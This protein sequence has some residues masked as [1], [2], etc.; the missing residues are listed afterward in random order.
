ML[1]LLLMLL[2]RSD[3]NKRQKTLLDANFCKL[4]ILGL[5]KRKKRRQWTSLIM[6][7]VAP[8]RFELGTERL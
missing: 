4:L 8:P 3:S 7:L 6:N 5:F 2:K 1:L